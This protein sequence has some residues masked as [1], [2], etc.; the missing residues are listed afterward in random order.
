MRMIYDVL[1][2]VGI[3]NDARRLSQSV[4]KQRDQ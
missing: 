2:Q 3:Q 4:I 1:Q